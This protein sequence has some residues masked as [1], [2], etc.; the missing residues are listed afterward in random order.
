MKTSD[1]QFGFKKDSSCNHAIFTLRKTIE[2]FVNNHSTVNLCSLDMSKA[3][4]KMNHYE[5]YLKLMDRSVPKKF[6]VLL[7]AWY[8]NLCTVVRWNNCYSKCVR[9][10]CGVHQGGILSPYLFA[11]FVDSVLEKLK[12]SNLVC[13]ILRR[14]VLVQSCMPT[15]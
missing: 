4:D 13:H 8:R 6:I 14:Y 5:L 15:I 11:V 1:L 12:L 2:Y 3:F 7:Y 9:L 10:V